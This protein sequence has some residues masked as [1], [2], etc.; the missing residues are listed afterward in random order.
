MFKFGLSENTWATI[1]LVSVYVLLM[2]L[3][4]GIVK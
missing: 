3:D 4:M 2:L 1:G